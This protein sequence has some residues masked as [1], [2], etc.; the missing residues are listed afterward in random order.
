MIP[1]QWY[2]V[3]ESK[4][5]PEG[6]PV[7]FRRLGQDLVFWRDTSASGER[8]IV[9]MRD[10][11]PHRQAKLS[12]GKL[13][14]G[15][16]E[17][18]FHGFLFDHAGACQL[19]P[20][21]GKNGPRPKIFQTKVYPS[22]EA[23]GFIWV[24]KGEPRKEYP[25]IPFF[26]GLE[27]YQYGSFHKEWTTHYTRAI[28]NQLDLA[29]LPF[30]HADTIGRG[31]KTL[32]NGPYS[33][34]EDESIYVWF[35]FQRDHG[36]VAHR[37]AELDKPDKSWQLS[38]KFPNIWMLRPSS[39]IQL[40]AAFAPIDDEKTMIY[41]RSYYKATK[42]QLVNVI[43]SKITALFSRKILS[44]DEEIVVTQ[45]LKQG[46]LDCGDKYIP[47]DRPILLYHTHRDELIRA[48]EWEKLSPAVSV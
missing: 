38:F 4:E 8:K 39:R 28:E 31:N 14:E 25:P 21:N 30:V 35:D 48:G 24:W 19:I 6:K 9:V 1:D 11:C 32:V 13:V 2:A 26:E 43:I 7:A 15:N 16:I 47:A 36:Q 12:K 17:C 29:H 42:Y 34:L 37:P 23:Y 27:E 46:G 5:V 3:V 22:R 18:P 20:A 40:F 41:I 45:T 33:I 44:Q 10:H